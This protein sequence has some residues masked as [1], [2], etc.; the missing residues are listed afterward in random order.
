M[1]QLVC[2]WVESFTHVFTESP[3]K[4]KFVKL[5]LQLS[6]HY[7]LRSFYFL[8]FF[9]NLVEAEEH[10]GASRNHACFLQDKWKFSTC[11]MTHK[12]EM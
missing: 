8:F 6:S 1:P 5:L 9:L 2:P 11:N 3:S 12:F 4:H 7:V 10:C